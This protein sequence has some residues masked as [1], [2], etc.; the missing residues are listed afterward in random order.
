MRGLILPKQVPNGVAIYLAACDEV[1]ADP[2][3]PIAA[4]M[5]Y[6][7]Q[8]TLR[9]TPLFEK[10]PAAAQV[11]ILKHEAAHFCLMHLP[12]MGDRQSLPWNAV[13]DC[14]LHHAGCADYE[15]VE[16]ALAEADPEH[17]R[18]GG[19]ATFE[20]L[21]LPPCPPE[22]AYDLLPKMEITIS[23]CGSMQASMSDGSDASNAKAAIVTVAIEA[24]DKEFMQKLLG[25]LRAGHDAGTGQPVPDLIPPPAWIREAIQ[26]ITMTA[27]R[28][29]RRR[30]W[31]REHRD[32]HDLPGQR[33]DVE[34][35][36][37]III[38]ASGST[39]GLMQQFLSAVVQTPE[40]A[41]SDVVVFDTTWSHPIAAAD[42]HGVA[43]AIGERGGGTHIRA[44]GHANRPAHLCVIW[45]TDG[46]SGDGWPDAHAST[47]VWCLP[48]GAPTPPAG[49]IVRIKE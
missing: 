26:H 42:I 47:E 17:R 38:D 19:S 13:T 41:N 35:V 46:E 36:C 8:M 28:N 30:S 25:G 34:P 18:V 40:L 3:I 49:V 44:A 12:R 45:L 24:G 10:I 22:I 31:M 7:G 9:L 11:E 43:A 21:G 1:V 29:V 33:R 5:L 48:E 39:A 2:A 37:R 23:S 16:R 27:R 20:R 15:L 4:T 32:S 14:S 6:E